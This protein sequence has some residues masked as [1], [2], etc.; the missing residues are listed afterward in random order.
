MTSKK[1]ILRG[2]EDHLT[3]LYLV[4]IETE[5]DDNI[6]TDIKKQSINRISTDY[7]ELLEIHTKLSKILIG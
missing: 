5:L 1:K 2:I 7:S 4:K 3:N 6:P